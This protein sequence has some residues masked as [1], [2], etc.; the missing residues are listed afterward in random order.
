M[1]PEL[2]QVDDHITDKV[3]IFALGICLFELGYRFETAM[4]RVKV[5]SALSITEPQKFGAIGAL[6]ARVMEMVSSDPSQRP[7]AADLLAF[8]LLHMADDISMLE[9]PEEPESD[10]RSCEVHHVDVHDIVVAMKVALLEK[11]RVIESQ[12][13]TIRTLQAQLARCF[14]AGPGSDISN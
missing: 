12:A 2:S 3:D 11:D 7:S 9:A 10:L 13:E 4:E 8:P 5:L 14:P 1:A 6:H